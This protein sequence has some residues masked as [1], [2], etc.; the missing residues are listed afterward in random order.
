MSEL[1][2]AIA[3]FVDRAHEAMNGLDYYGILGVERGATTEDVRDAYYRLA[4][5][6]HPDVY[7]DTLSDA[8]RRKLTAV[9]SRVVE[10]YQVLSS[11]MMRP[12]YDQ[13]LGDGW[14][15]WD[16]GEARRPEPAPELSIEHTGAR[17]FFQLAGDAAAAG[18]WRAAATNYRLAR[19]LDPDNETIRARLEEAEAK[20]EKE[21]VR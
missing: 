15:R 8:S 12:R 5:R 18:D 7:G 14:L 19:S 9:F 17:R 6:L 4:R 2:P 20:L 13:L 21:I 10:A 3:T 16:E 11:P 1:P